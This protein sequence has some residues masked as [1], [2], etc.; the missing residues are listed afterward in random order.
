VSLAG[1]VV[2]GA[3][4]ALTFT[5]QRLGIRSAWFYVIPAFVMWLGML[6]AGIHPAIAGVALGLMTPVHFASHSEHARRRV[7]NA[8][9]RIGSPQESRG[10]STQELAAPLRELKDAQ[11]DL[12]PP[13]LRVQDALHPWVAFVVMPL[14]A[15]A[16]AG[17]TLE[18]LQVNSSFATVFMGVAGGLVLG[19]PLGIALATFLATRAGLCELPRGVNGGAII[20]MG[21]LGGIGFT[22]AIFIANLAFS[23]P[24]LLAS[25]K[26]AVL[27]SSVTAAIAG[28][29]VG[30]RVL[31]RG[32][33]Y[34]PASHGAHGE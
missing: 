17:V 11:N 18:G 30:R 29:L 10:K 24:E 34:V 28:Y 16:N 5:F 14:F 1:L 20:T 21:C 23:S 15:L 12:L 2:A 19:K 4:A 33:S 3:A 27:A 8:L 26:A 7:A 31:G 32:T 6:G 25:V 9:A 13:V 22:M